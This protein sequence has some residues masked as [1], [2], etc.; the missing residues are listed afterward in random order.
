MQL[1]ELALHVDNGRLVA[2]DDWVVLVVDGSQSGADGV[3]LLL[4][5]AD[6]GQLLGS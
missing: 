6:Q 3:G 5:G 4:L 2:G 1:L